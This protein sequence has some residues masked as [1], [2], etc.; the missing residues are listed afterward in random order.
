MNIH[1]GH[2]ILGAIGHFA[3]W[4]VV[5]V[6]IESDIQAIQKI[7]IHTQK[8]Q[9]RILVPAILGCEKMP[10]ATETSNSACRCILSPPCTQSVQITELYAV[11]TQGTRCAM[12]HSMQAFCCF[13]L[14][15]FLNFSHS[16]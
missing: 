11:N 12:I 1:F 14:V 2:H 16:E 5:S 7:Y 4:N 9:A 8:K 6:P 15:A 10:F 3:G 13:V